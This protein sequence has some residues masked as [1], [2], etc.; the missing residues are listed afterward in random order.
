MVHDS[1]MGVDHRG[2]HVVAAEQ[3]L[4]RAYVIAAFEQMRG[5]RV[6]ERVAG[7]APGQSGAVDGHA[8]GLLR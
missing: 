1:S 7:G 2:L 6:S 4:H 3:F 8:D 5:E